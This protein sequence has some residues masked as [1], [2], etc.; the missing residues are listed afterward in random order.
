MAGCLG[1]ALAVAAAGCGGGK[2]ERPPTPIAWV[3]PPA[4]ATT[5]GLPAFSPE[6]DAD[7]IRVAR[8]E[9]A[10][11]LTLPSCATAWEWMG[12]AARYPAALPAGEE[13]HA[14]LMDL[15]FRA[16]EGLFLRSGAC[17]QTVG[18]RT[19]P[20][21]IYGGEW[22]GDDALLVGT[23]ALQGRCLYIVDPAGSSPAPAARP[24]LLAFGIGTGRDGQSETVSYADRE[25]RVGEVVQ[26]G[27]SAGG[28]REVSM[29]WLV[30]PAPECERELIWFVAAAPIED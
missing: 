1:L 29:R 25:L 18:G 19:G 7:M 11:E 26:A 2:D 23:L 8:G 15:C 22:N 12:A 27:G 16:S 10:I 14:V 6:C 5:T 13:A 17:L 24:L 9:A 3:T 20:L 28:R 30:S 4:P 21:A